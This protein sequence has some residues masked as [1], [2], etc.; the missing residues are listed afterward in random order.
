MREKEK[1]LVARKAVEYLRDGIVL[2]VGSGSTVKYFIEFLGEKIHRGELSDIKAIPSSH[3]T[4]LLLH[5]KG[6][7]CVDLIDYPNIDITVDGADS[8]HLSKRVLI[9]GGGGAFLR[10]K[11][12]G[13][14]AKRFIVIIDESKINRSFPVPVEVSSFGLGY[15]LKRLKKL[16]DEVSIR[17]C[18][19][20]LGPCI[21]D[22]GNIIVDVQFKAENIDRMLEAKLNAIPGVL[23]NGIF[24]RDAEII[25]GKRDG[26]IEIRRI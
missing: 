23:E 14:A 25:I 9:K 2:G 22:N 21:S 18:S 5:K 15:V 10:E 13:Y 4:R 16:A 3:D 6:I 19:G 20:K 17:K 8:V 7:K 24:T 11:I 26:G 1:I 12:I